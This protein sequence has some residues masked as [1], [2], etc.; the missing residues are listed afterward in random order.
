[1]T[2]VFV[3][4]LAY[5]LGDQ[6][7]S[8]EESVAAGRTI[9][10]PQVLRDAGFRQHH[11]CSAQETAYDLAKGAL[12]GMGADLSGI[13]A[14]V[15]ATCI[16]MNGSIGDLELFHKTRDVKHLMDFPASHLQADF[17]LDRAAVIGLN[18]QA[19]TGMLGSLRLARTLLVAEPEVRKVLCITADRFP[20]EALYEQ[21]YNLI[22]DGGAACLVST[23]PEGYRIV[24]WHSITNGALASASDDETVGT[25]FNYTHRLIQE[26]LAK[27]R[28]E[29]T[30][31]RWIV[32]QN[33]NVKAW[34][35]LARLLRVDPDSVFFGTIGEVAHVV[36]GDNIINLKRLTDEGR[37]QPGDRVLLCMAGYG[38]NWQCMILE[39]C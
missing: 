6:R 39:K 30:D 29:I 16:P 1:M 34:Q 36:S 9:S 26:T 24:A 12:A 21:A 8:V 15:Y 17:G 4:H 38:L 22:S 13:G 18:Q 14:V 25:Y 23:E 10:T 7:H 37:I 2:D 32:P 27:A 31:I 11:V 20:P 19:C 33:M 35:I 3:D 28:I 5:A